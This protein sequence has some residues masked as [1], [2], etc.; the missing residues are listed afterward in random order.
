VLQDGVVHVRHEVLLNEHGVLEEIVGLEV[1]LEREAGGLL[2]LL[3]VLL[4]VVLI[5]GK[6]I[7]GEG[8]GG[9]VDE[10]LERVRVLLGDLLAEELVVAKGAEPELGDALRRLLFGVV[11]LI[12]RC[13][14]STSLVPL[15][16]AARV[17]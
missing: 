5:L 7:L 6:V 3:L 8:A 1:E 11:A 13:S 17:A 14:A 9:D 16:M 15:T 10:V 4:L 2:L 12:M